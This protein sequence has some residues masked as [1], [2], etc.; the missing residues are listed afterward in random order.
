MT[1][2]ETATTEAEAPVKAEE[3]ASE[4]APMEEKEA[5]TEKPKTEEAV[6]VE[7]KEEATEPKKEAKTEIKEDTP[8]KRRYTVI[9]TDI[10][11]ERMKVMGLTRDSYRH[12]WD[13]LI[14]RVSQILQVIIPLA[15][16]RRRHYIIDQINVTP[17]RA[18][19]IAEFKRHKK[20]A[21]VFA[22]PE[23]IRYKYVQTAA[24]SGKVVPLPAVLQMKQEFAMPRAKPQGLFDEDGAT[25][26]PLDDASGL[27]PGQ[28]RHAARR[29]LGRTSPGLGRTENAVHTRLRTPG[30][31][32]ARVWRLE[33]RLPPTAWLG[34]AAVDAA[35]YV[36]S[37]AT[38]AVAT[39]A[40]ANAT[41]AG[42]GRQGS[43]RSRC[44]CAGGRDGGTHGYRG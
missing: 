12:R 43:G 24:R 8:V 21:V 44:R 35:S 6:K 1:D 27:G 34:S 40:V 25:P 18:R 26:A 23:N 38:A 37:A 20:I 29:G 41:T 31:G 10:L 16:T 15:A 7:T 33:P 11:I 13:A 3:A 17:A 5:A 2:E 19:K 9:G 28:A 4:A 36:P 22:V 30:L 32:Q 39:P 42:N 14:S